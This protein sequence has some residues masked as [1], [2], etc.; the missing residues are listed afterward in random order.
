MSQMDKHPGIPGELNNVSIGTTI[1]GSQGELKNVSNSTTIHGSQGSLK[2][3]SI[4]TTIHGLHMKLKNVSNS[5]TMHESQEELKTCVKWNNHTWIPRNLHKAI[6]NLGDSRS[7][8]SSDTHADQ[9][10]PSTSKSPGTRGR[11]RQR[12]IGQKLRCHPVLALS[13]LAIFDISE[14]PPGPCAIET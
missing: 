8:A 13:L 6:P 14:I 10:L 11:P 12:H 7:R 5:T 9:V 4:G 2:H 1:H 3:V